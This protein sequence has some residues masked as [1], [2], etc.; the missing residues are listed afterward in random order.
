MVKDIADKHVESDDE[1]NEEGEGEVVALA[2]RSLE[3][4]GRGPRQG[5]V[6]G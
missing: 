3:L 6:E 1:E 5:L 2:Q 4:L